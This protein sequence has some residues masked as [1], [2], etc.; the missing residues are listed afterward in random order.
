MSDSMVNIA[1]IMSTYNGGKYLKT[2]IDSILNQKNVDVTLYIRDDGSTD[3]TIQLLKEYSIKHSNVIVDLGSNLGFARSFLT[4]LSKARSHDYYAFSDQDDYWEPLK[5]YSAVSMMEKSKN[6]LVLYYSNLNVTDE[7]LNIFKK[8][9]LEKR[10]HSLKSVTLRRS[11]AGCTMVFSSSLKEH[12][13]KIEIQRIEKGISHDSILMS[14][15]YGLDADVICDS[16]AYISYR[17]HGNNTSGSSKGLFGRLKKE[18]NFIK[19]LK[20]NE[21]NLAGLLLEVY[22]S[23]LNLTQRRTLLRIHASRNNIISR[24]LIIFDPSFATGVFLLTIHGKI[25]VFLGVL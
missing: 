16:E 17:Q 2:Q 23:Q 1:V 4:E 14:L 5:L 20:H 13:G 11:I 18:L 22:G 15:A 7:N 10:N 25:R 24:L 3:N 21:T 6:N 8:T 19:V 9:K 12:V